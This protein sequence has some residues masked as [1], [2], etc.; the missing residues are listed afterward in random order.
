MSDLASNRI[1][2]CKKKKK[3]Y[4]IKIPTEKKKTKNGYEMYLMKC[5]KSIVLLKEIVMDKKE[6]RGREK[7]KEEK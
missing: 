3:V 4:K 7:E 5:K 2:N 1:R 6:R